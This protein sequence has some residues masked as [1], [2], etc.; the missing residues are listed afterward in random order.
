MAAKGIS[1]TPA[2]FEKA[3]PKVNLVTGFFAPVDF[4]SKGPVPGYPRIHAVSLNYLTVQN[5]TIVPI[6]HRNFNVAAALI[7]YPNG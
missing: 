2:N 7:K 6:S 4:A 3:I 1:F 5:G